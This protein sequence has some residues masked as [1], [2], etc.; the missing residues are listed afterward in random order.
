MID[1]STYI[2]AWRW[3]VAIFASLLLAWY[4]LRKKS[5]DKSGA[6][7]GIVVGFLLTISN[8]CLEISGI[9]VGFLLSISYLC[10]VISDIV[11]GFLLTISNMCL[12]I[13][14]I[15]VGFQ[16]T[17][18]N[19]CL[20]VSDIVVGFLLSISNMCLVISDIA[21]GFLD[22]SNMCLVISGIVV[23]F[24]LTISNLCFFTSLLTF[25]LLASKATKYKS[26]M[27]KKFEEDFK[28]GG[29][30]NWVQV[31]CNGGIA[32]M[33]AMIYMLDNGAGEMPVDFSKEYTP[34]FF[35]M[36][37]LGALACS[38]GDTF[39]SELGTVFKYNTQPRLITTFRKVP[40]GTNGGISLVGTFC[41]LI[42]G[43]VVGM[44]YYLTLIFSL[45]D[46]YLQKCPP[47]WPIILLGAIAGVLGSTI[48]SYLGAVFQYSGYNRVTH[49]IV[50]TEGKDVEHIC[51]CALLDN[52]SVNLLSSLFCGL[53]T[54]KVAFYLWWLL[55]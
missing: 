34:S 17:I 35:S 12:V 40:T 38:C 14:G 53:L 27:K 30:R 44:A 41:S 48:D 11:V 26:L 52:H 25:F 47:Q 22:Y 23:G 6:V 36:A 1:Y 7:A 32:S 50:E 8:L 37:V 55:L 13:S 33:F 29:Q 54:P 3:L 19:L 39:A 9:V 45:S 49:K 28:E 10:L 5:L 43:L 46:V 20:E 18:S 15:V 51:G 4:G 2:A 21:V 31:I 24:L 16:L 42:G